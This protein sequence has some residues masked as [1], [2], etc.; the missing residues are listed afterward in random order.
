MGAKESQLKSYHH[1]Y[2]SH[3][4]DTLTLCVGPRH[5]LYPEEAMK[6]VRSMMDKVIEISI[7]ASR[8][9]AAQA[10]SSG[11]PERSVVFH[12]FSMGGFLFGQALRAMQEAPQRYG[13]MPHLI[14]AQVFDSPPDFD[15]IST[16]ISKSLGLPRFLESGARK[17]ADMYL[18]ATAETSGAHHRAASA[19]FH[20]NFVSAPA[21]WYYSKADPIAEWRSC[22]QVIG[23]WRG[24][25]TDVTVCSWDDTPHVLHARE[26]PE[27]YFSTLQGFLEKASVIPASP[28]DET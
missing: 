16:G 9:E 5:V 27:R 12:S 19:A 24:R 3:G 26:H 13:V 2:H 20:Q 17:I 1:F 22:E 21:L 18:S 15:G 14:R 11:R 7:D 25:G 8:T 6:A 4:M 23:K 10:G 28:R